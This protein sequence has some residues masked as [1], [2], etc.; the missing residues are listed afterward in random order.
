LGTKR[1]AV[2]GDGDG[3]GGLVQAWATREDDGTVRILVW[4]VTFD[5]TKARGSDALAREVSLAVTGLLPS[6]RFR[7]RHYRVDNTHSN[8]YGAW[9]AMGRPDW[10]NAQQLT[11]L[12]RR[13]E[14]EMLEPERSRIAD[15]SG[16]AQLQFELPMPS[17]SLIEMVPVRNGE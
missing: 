1:I 10:P 14:L 13:D 12:H 11:E 6:Q 16:K 8:V 5:Q 7:Q 2:D 4:N 17:L 15:A 9:Q 3:F